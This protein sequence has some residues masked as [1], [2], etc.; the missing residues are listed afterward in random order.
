MSHNEKTSLV[1]NLHPTDVEL[2]ETEVEGAPK[3]QRSSTAATVLYYA[4]VLVVVLVLFLIIFGAVDNDKNSKPTEPAELIKLSGYPLAKCLDS[5]PAAMYFRPSKTNSKN[6]IIYLDGG[7]DCDTGPSC[8]LV[9]RLDKGTSSVYERTISENLE[10]GKWY[11]QGDFISPFQS[12][13]PGFYDANA[14]YGA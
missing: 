1:S 9:L 3:G 5:T 13:N 11:T 2:L 14:I 12:D 4:V 6:W 8:D 10:G 7:F